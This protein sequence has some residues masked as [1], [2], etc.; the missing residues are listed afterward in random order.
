MVCP[1]TLQLTVILNLPTFCSPKHA[2]FQGTF[3]Q[4]AWS[5]YVPTPQDPLPEMDLPGRHGGLPFLVTTFPLGGQ[6]T[7]NNSIPLTYLSSGGD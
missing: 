6:K 4:E 2:P 5:P 1:H 3:S 7:E